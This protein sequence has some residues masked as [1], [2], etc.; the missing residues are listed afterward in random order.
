MKVVLIGSGNVATHLGKAL[1]GAGHS[2]L[3]VYSR[4][5]TGAKALARKLSCTYTNNIK[6]ISDKGDVYLIAV[7]DEAIEPFVKSFPST[8]KIVVH[9]SGSVPINVLKEKFRNC[10]VMYPV[11]SFSIDRELDLTNVPFCIEAG[12]DGVKKKITA[13]IKK[14][15]HKIHDIDSAQRKK[16]HLAAVFANNFANHLFEISEHLLAIE[17]IPFDIIRPLIVETAMK[18]Q[19]HLPA[20][21]QTGPAKRGDKKVIKE[22]LELLRNKK[23]F[24]K[25]YKLL[26]ESISDM[27]GIRF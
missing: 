18:V 25:I 12:N 8:D 17:N 11:Q 7:R 2:I 10:G 4:S 16:I 20:E 22:H 26:S 27:N 1:K 23:K 13:L 6:N 21:M 5:E 9:T 3:Q 19:S 14:V 15:S 24:K